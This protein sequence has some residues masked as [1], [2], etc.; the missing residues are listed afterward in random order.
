ME[1]ITFYDQLN[2]TKTPSRCH[3]EEQEHGA[4]TDESKS[5]HNVGSALVIA[6]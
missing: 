3:G 2:K 6:I 4:F 5:G 1:S